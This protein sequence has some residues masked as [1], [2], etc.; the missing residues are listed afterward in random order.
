MKE[1]YD[2]YQVL[3][4]GTAVTNF[5]KFRLPF[6]EKAIALY[7]DDQL[8][9]STHCLPTLP[10]CK[11]K[12]LCLHDKRRFTGR[13]PGIGLGEFWDILWSIDETLPANRKV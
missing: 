1:T 9:I 8:V 2:A 13:K 6:F 4:G 5:D 3:H 11:G 7:G 12:I 10:M